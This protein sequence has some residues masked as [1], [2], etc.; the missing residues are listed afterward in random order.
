MNKQKQTLCICT[1]SY[2]ED[3]KSDAFETLDEY[4]EYLDFLEMKKAKK[5][6]FEM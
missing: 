6:D 4:E 2:S 1:D 3:I 5:K